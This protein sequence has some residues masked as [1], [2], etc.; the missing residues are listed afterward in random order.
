MSASTP[1]ERAEAA[2]IRRRWITLGE[3]IAVVGLLISGLAL[4][5]NWSERRENA[6]E[7]RAEQIETRRARETVLLAGTPEDGGSRLMIGD[8][9]RP[10]QS[11]SIRFPTALGT[12]AQQVS[13]RPRIEARWFAAKLLAMTDKG[14]DER[15]GRLP[16][17]ITSDYWDGDRH[18]TDRAIYEVV[19]RTE[20]RMLQGRALRLEGLT[21]RERGGNQARINALWKTLAPAPKG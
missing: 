6:D 1:E 20:G 9:A 7:R 8:P 3:V 14:Q 10:I 2:A 11:V 17:L 5:T 13:A 18:V 4:W 12:A 15:E 16:V 21:L 19:W